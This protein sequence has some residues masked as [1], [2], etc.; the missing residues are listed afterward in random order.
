MAVDPVA[1]ATAAKAAVSILP[2]EKAR[3][4][5]F[6]LMIAPLA[7]FVLLVS[8]FY[9]IL[10][11]PLQTLSIF[12]SGS[13]LTAAQNV[14]IEHGYDQ[15]ISPADEDYLSS[16]GLDFSGVS[17]TDGA[18]TVH[19][20]SQLDERWKNL[21]YGP[22]DTI[23]SSGC[24][25]T[26]LAM[27]VS[28]LTSRIIEPVQMC[29]WAYQ[30]GYLCEGSGSYHS[31]I[32]DGAKHFGLAVDYANVN[33]PQK[34]VDALASGKL[35]IAILGPGHFTKSGHFIVLR[36]V[37]SDRKILVADP[38]S[39]TR[40]EQDW[41]LAII[42]NEARNNASAGGPLWLLGTLPHQSAINNYN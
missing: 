29:N 34:I 25:P 41:D 17:F 32:P 22:S 27:V 21:P 7:G 3:K 11:M 35:V 5:L 20:F 6:I 36:G 18:T 38:A 13:I 24:G 33:E 9:Y 4:T 26:S 23:G 28:S 40:S 30:N 19:Y 16:E 39:K 37:T 8:L 10:T 1:I 2:D 12:F 31:L 14:R 15:Y 42:L